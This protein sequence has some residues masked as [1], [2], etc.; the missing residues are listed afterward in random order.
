MTE[1]FKNKPFLFIVFSAFLAVMGIGIVIPVLPF[2]VGQ[3]IDPNDTN[4]TGLIV[5]LLLSVYALFQFFSAPVFGALSDKYG[6]RPILLFCLLG[7][8]VGYILFGIGGSLWI[9]FLSRIIDG[10]TGGDI[11]TLMAY[12]ADITKPEERGK[13]FGIIGATVGFG[14][15]IGPSIG[16]LV[17]QFSL[18]APVYLAAGLTLL[19]VIY[20][21][22]FLPESLSKSNRMAD[23]TIHHLNPFTQLAYVFKNTLIRAVLITGLF[24]FLPF[25]QLQGISGVFFKDT[26]SWSPE[27]IGYYFLVL[28]VFDMFTQGYLVGKLLPK[29]GVFK[30]VLG[31]FLVTGLAFTIAAILPIYPLL[32]LSIAY[33]IIYSLGSGLF[34]PSY[35][36]LISGLASPKDQGRVQG[37]SQ[38]FQ[39]IT[40]IIGPILAG[41]LY[42]FNHSLTWVMCVIFSILG[43]FLLFQNKKEISTHLK[44]A[45]AH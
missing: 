26:M 5:G 18:S 35:G 32:F 4:S 19:N 43:V 22:F 9:L 10:I 34:E 15:I 11:S 39:S 13:Y 2:I 8:A 42:Q 31:G 12:I 29:F 23:F 45:S 17:S 16:G 3:Y 14:F 21:Y 37:A 40:R 30:L 41:F 28:G 27:N 33:I 38:S 36:G 7:S 1:V 24:Y 25:A 20:G 44:T 6:R